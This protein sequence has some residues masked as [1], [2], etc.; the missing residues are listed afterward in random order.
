M[1]EVA[2]YVLDHGSFVGVPP[3]S[4]A[5]SRHGAYCYN[6]ELRELGMSKDQ[7]GKDIAAAATNEGT[8]KSKQ[9]LLKLPPKVGSVQ[10][11]VP[12]TADAENLGNSYWDAEVGLLSACTMLLLNQLAAGGATNCNA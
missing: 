5:V 3:T 9:L 2:A 8:V 1:R 7:P 4:M 10:M 11:F 12:H 6:A